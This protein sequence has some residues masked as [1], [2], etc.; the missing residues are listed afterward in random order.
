LGS[1]NKLFD[2]L[3]RS[4]R[5]ENDGLTVDSWQLPSEL[6]LC[7]QNLAIQF[8]NSQRAVSAPV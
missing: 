2:L 8:V 7:C 5:E 6:R 4:A 1:I 3:V